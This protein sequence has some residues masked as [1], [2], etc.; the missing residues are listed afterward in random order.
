MHTLDDTI[1]EIDA[2]IAAKTTGTGAST[3]GSGV[4]A[5]APA[6]AMTAAPPGHK[7]VNPFV[8]FRQRN[9]SGGFLNCDLVKM[10]HNT[11]ALLRERGDNKTKVEPGGG[12]F[13]VNPDGMID[14]WTKYVD[15]KPVERRIYR[16]AEGEMAPPSARMSATPTSASGRSTTAAA[17]ARTRG[18]APCFCP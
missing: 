16:T 10:D 12:R 5:T 11:G 14:T 15:G 2:A 8:L 3:D 13:I 17:S 4:P 6:T 18:S 7:L 1:D 9:A